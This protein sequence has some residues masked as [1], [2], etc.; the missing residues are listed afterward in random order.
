MTDKVNL[1]EKFAGF[2]E[3]YVPKIVGELNG[4][5]VKVAKFKGPYPWHFHADE[6]EMF[7]VVRGTMR[8]CLRD[9]EY[10]L[11]AGEFCIIPR[12]VEHR[13][14]ADE[15]VDVVLFEPATTLNTGNTRN[16]FTRE[17]LDRI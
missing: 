16:E 9:R 6:D 4:Q 14:D 10:E 11:N 1:A 8:M 3:V 12:G 13:P 5:Y 15:V 7:L 17:E 2:D